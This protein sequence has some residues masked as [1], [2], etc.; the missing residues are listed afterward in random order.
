MP[1]ACGVPPGD[2]APLWTLLAFALGLA[3]L[4]AVAI[5]VIDGAWDPVYAVDNVCKELSADSHD[6]RQEAGRPFQ[7]VLGG[8]TFLWAC[9][10]CVRSSNT[11]PLRG[12]RRGYRVV[13]A[14]AVLAVTVYTSGMVGAA[15]EFEGL[16]MV[17]VTVVCLLFS[18]ALGGGFALLARKEA[19]PNAGFWG[20]AGAWAAAAVCVLFAGWVVL[21]LV[22]TGEVP[23]C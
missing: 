4:T 2:L 19:R 14:P 7:V 1:Q 3:V 9:V 6:R 17:L 13:C 11:F 12:L 22:G 15:D 18:G 20:W 23:I 21:G 5:V 10:F 8:W 16:A